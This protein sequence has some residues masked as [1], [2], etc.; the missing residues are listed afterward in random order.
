MH[1]K[2][3]LH[4]AP[5]SLTM[6]CAAAAAG[7]R[8]GFPIVFHAPSQQHRRQR[9]AFAGLLGL[10]AAVAFLLPTTRVHAQGDGSLD[11]SFD[12]GGGVS[13]NSDVPVQ[14]V[15]IQSDGKIVLA[16][17]FDGVNGVAHRNIARLN[18]DGS[19]DTGFTPDV[20]QNGSTNSPNI[21]AVAVQPDGKILLGGIFNTV[22]GVTR[23][24]IARLNADGSLDM[25]F[26]A[27]NDFAN[28]ETIALQ[29]DGKIVLGGGFSTFNGV[30]RKNIL[31]LN[32]DGSLDTSFDPGS[33]ANSTVYA[34]ALQPDGKIVIG[35]DFSAINDVARSRLARLN[36]NGSLDTAFNPGSGAN[37]TV[38]A[39]A[40]QPDG[41]IVIGG[42]YFDSVN[43]VARS[44]LA[45]LNSDG[46]LDT[47]FHPST[48]TGYVF[49]L[50]LQ[51]DG[52]VVIGG[53]FRVV[54]GVAR[55]D[56]ARLNADG[57]LDLGFD[58]G[59]GSDGTVLGVA[60]QADG[61]IVLGGS[62]HFIDGVARNQIARLN[63]TP[64]GPPPSP[65][66]P[67]FFNGETALGDNLFYLQFPNGNFFGFYS[68]LY[69]PFLYH[70]D[71]GYEY[72]F[73]VNDGEGG[74]YLYDYPSGHYFYSSP[75]YP[76][77]YLYDYT[78]GAILYYFPDPNREGHYSSSPRTFVNLS[79]GEIISL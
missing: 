51:P 38:F 35:G 64:P 24:G 9:A 21:N 65:T 76:F 70:Y 46:S 11:T 53:V 72:V 47:A 41:K 75:N 57:S 32:A 1:S 28:F 3:C 55:H 19:L 52:K 78:L 31:R 4:L 61:K 48:D 54:N 27:S 58:P 12:P 69:Y 25:G 18:P 26:G 66:H 63:G 49:S 10:L 20:T 39:T 45:R 43:N 13:S 73:D 15:A 37:G 6:L 7:R 23:S 62:F 36:A 14:S 74:I 59:S 2:T 5:D 29:S 16:G 34:T 30:A 68:D 40:L 77:P 33:G 79:T 60:L 8:A 42:G 67:P 56:I 17:Q 22:N 50:A 44:L 71:L